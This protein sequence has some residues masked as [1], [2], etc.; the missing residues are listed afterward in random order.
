MPGRPGPGVVTDPG[1][2]RRYRENWRGEIDGAA[3]YCA[4]AASEDDPNL[5]EVYR[6]LAEV[7]ERHADFWAEHLRAAGAEV[8]AARPGWRARILGWLA[9]RFGAG[10]VAPTTTGWFRT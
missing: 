10:F 4:M 5:A 8:P 2:V 9:R 3:I 6:R 1:S 7:E